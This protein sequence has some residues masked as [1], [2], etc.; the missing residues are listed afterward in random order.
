MRF[1]R[2]ICFCG[3]VVF[4]L[5]CQHYGATHKAATNKVDD[6]KL[7]SVLE[8]KELSNEEKLL[9]LAELLHLESPSDVLSTQSAS[10]LVGGPKSGAK[11]VWSEKDV[12]LMKTVAAVCKKEGGKWWCE[13]TPS[14]GKKC[15]VECHKKD[16]GL[17]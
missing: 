1:L 10:P 6:K 12:R 16:D 15:A 17:K 8:N 14:G 3:L 2:R 4:L 11:N 9:A 13:N 5:S 7:L